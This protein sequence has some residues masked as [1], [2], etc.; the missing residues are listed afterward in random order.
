MLVKT[1][2]VGALQ[3]NCTIFGDEDAG[4]AFVV[5]PGDDLDLID[6][7]LDRHAL[8]VKGVLITH[9][10]IDHIG[11]AG[12]FKDRLGAPMYLHEIDQKLYDNIAQQAAWLGMPAPKQ[13][14]V[15]VYWNEG[16]VL[17]LGSIEF[18]VRFTPG[19]APGH[20]SLWIPSLNT[21]VAGDTLFAGSIGR[22]DLPGGNHATLIKSIRQKLFTLPDD[23]EVIPGHGQTTTIGR[24]KRFNPFL[25]D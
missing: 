2:A 15:D 22:T 8:K 4:E 21:V 13:F 25:N 11:R 20:V 24:E 23:A 5:D 10:H 7:V 14:P 3:C 9:A 1:L 18:H 19:H 16:D 12:E 6:A 17:K